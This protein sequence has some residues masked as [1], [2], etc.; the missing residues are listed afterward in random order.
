MISKELLREVLGYNVISVDDKIY[1]HNISFKIPDR[2]KSF[3][4]RVIKLNQ[5]YIANKCKIWAYNHK[6][7]LHSYITNNSAICSIDNREDSN[8]I[9]DTEAEA[10][11]LGAEWIL[12]N[13]EL[14]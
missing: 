4:E 6:Y 8:F 3:N 11:F 2:G 12:N 10:V 9:A 1:K 14:T 13:K 5:H 7:T